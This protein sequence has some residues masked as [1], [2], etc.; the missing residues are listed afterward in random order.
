M[1]LGQRFK[2][3]YQKQT[4]KSIDYNKKRAKLDYIKIC[5]KKKKKSS[6]KKYKVKLQSRKCLQKS[7]IKGNTHICISTN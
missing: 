3:G 2:G 1:T 4:N 7:L 6:L 5:C